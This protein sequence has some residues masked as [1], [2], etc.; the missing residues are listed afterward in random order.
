[1]FDAVADVRE[2]IASAEADR[3]IEAEV[4]DAFRKDALLEATE[5]SV[6]AF[7]AGVRSGLVAPLGQ[8]LSFQWKRFRPRTPWNLTVGDDGRLAIEMNG[9]RRSFGAL[10]AGE[11]TIAL[12]LLRVAL[13]VAFTSTRFLVLDEPLEHLDPRTRRLLISSLQHAVEQGL[14]DQLIVS[15]YEETIVRRLQR[16]GLASAV[17]L[18]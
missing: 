15:T 2:E 17:Y 13:S 16:D 11:R 6:S 9:E 10:S 5:N 1:M 18:D 3:R 14:V 7:I 4:V 8:E 12:I